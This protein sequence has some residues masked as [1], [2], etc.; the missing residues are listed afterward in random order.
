ME[1]NAFTRRMQFF[2]PD[3]EIFE[4]FYNLDNGK[5][6]VYV[7]HYEEQEIIDAIIDPKRLLIKEET[8]SIKF[9]YPL[10]N[11][12]T[13]E[14][15]NKEGFTRMDLLRCIYEGYKKIYETE[16]EDAGDPG[17][18][19]KLYNRRTSE[20]RYGIWG[21]YLND[22]IIEGMVYDSKTKLVE[23]LIGS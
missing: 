19:E 16:E 17:T 3:K 21:H 12:V 20:G 11:K 10:T 14:Y 4:I 8:I 1:D 6:C 7:I 22:L 13:F 9:S 23:L 15:N 2:Y 5:A 18:Y